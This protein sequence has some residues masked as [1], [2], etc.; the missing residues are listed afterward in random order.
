M[1]CLTSVFP[2]PASLEARATSHVEI[3]HIQGILFDELA[4]TLDVLAHKRRENLFALHGVFELHLKKS[5]LFGI[6]RR[7]SE[8]LRVHLAETLVALDRRVL[9][10]LILHE[11]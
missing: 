4:P 6:H 11:L 3:L 8:L 9:L 2:Q 10:A 1:G 7:L 5:A